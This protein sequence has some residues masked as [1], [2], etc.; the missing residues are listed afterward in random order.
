MV[1]FDT[2][3]YHSILNTN[4]RQEYGYNRYGNGNIP[5]DYNIFA[6]ARSTAT[7]GYPNS[8]QYNFVNK[9]MLCRDGYTYGYKDWASLHAAI[10]EAN[11][12]SMYEF[13][14]DIT[15]EEYN[16]LHHTHYDEIDDYKHFTI[17]PGLTLKGRNKKGGIFINTSDVLIE[18]EAC[19]IDMDQTH[20]SFGANAKGITIRGITFRGASTSSL[21]FHD[22]GAQVVFEDCIWMGNAGFGSAG[23]VADLN[24]TS[25]VSFYRCEISDSKQLPRSIG[26]GNT[27]MSSSL[28]IRN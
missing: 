24:S 28:T 19:V 8:M 15:D 18:C 14:P 23:A 10:Q 3:T 13:T 5:I 7:V 9:P 25:S 6:D 4:E 12:F 26:Y 27:A 22:H 2:D 11:E 1:L 16:T 20:F 17:C 21:T